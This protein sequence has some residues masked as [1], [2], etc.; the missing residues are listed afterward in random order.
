MSKRNNRIA[1]S[2][3]FLYAILIFLVNIVLLFAGEITSFSVIRT[4]VLFSLSIFFMIMFFARAKDERVRAERRAKKQAQRVENE[5]KA[6]AAMSEPA[7]PAAVKAV[8]TRRT[9]ISP[10][11]LPNMIGDA[12]RQRYYA[13]DLTLADGIDV[14]EILG[15]QE[16][17]VACTVA[18]GK[19]IFEY[20][21]SYIGYVENSSAADMLADWVRRGDPYMPVLREPKEGRPRVSITF[22]KDRRK[23]AEDRDQ[24][25]FVLAS[26]KSAAKQERISYVSLA[27]ELKICE[28]DDGK[29]YEVLFDGEPIG[30]L[31]GKIAKRYDAEGCY[32]IFVEDLQEEYKDNGDM[33]TIPILRIIY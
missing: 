11:F 6:A 22:Y 26:C 13:Y 16:R 32:G 23:G 25:V 8:P 2:T 15:G 24:E 17:D 31:P 14:Y 20:N 21:G 9:Y 7:K 3:F 5:A 29:S 27:E 1:S 19:I 30:K 18:E 28:A 10:R 4:F 12:T 33:V